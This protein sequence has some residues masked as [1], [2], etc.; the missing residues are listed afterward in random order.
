[1]SKPWFIEGATRSIESPLSTVVKNALGGGGPD[2]KL[3]QAPETT[4]NGMIEPTGA[5]VIDLPEPNTAQ[6]PP[7]S[8]P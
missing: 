1:M 7:P 8:G 6:R 4:R 5:P 2:P 3:E